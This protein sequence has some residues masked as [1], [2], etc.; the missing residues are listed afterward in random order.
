MAGNRS[1]GGDGGDGESELSDGLGGGIMNQLGAALYVTGSAITN[2]LAQ[3]G[4]NATVTADNPLTGDGA[5]GGIYNLINGS[6]TVTS[7]VIDGN[8]ATAV[9]RLPAP[10]AAPLAV[11]S[12]VSSNARSL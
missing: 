3:G 4:N 11:G 1:V 12:G 2:N 5:G 6:V 10:A 7:S 9:R 8:E